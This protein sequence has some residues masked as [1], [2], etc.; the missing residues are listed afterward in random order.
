MCH[1]GVDAY[2]SNLLGRNI[3]LCR[4]AL[5]EN[6]QFLLSSNW[7]TLKIEEHEPKI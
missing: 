4:V 3:W 7:S 6:S 5:P 2:F 1:E